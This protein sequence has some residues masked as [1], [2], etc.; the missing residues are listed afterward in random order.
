MS[1]VLKFAVVGHPNEGK[2]SVVSTLA[3]DDTVPV[4]AFPGETVRCASYP[5]KIDGEE[6]IDFIDTP[7]FQN[8][9][10]MKEWMQAHGEDG[11]AL[12]QAFIAAHK[13]QPDYHHDVELLRPI[14]EGAGIIYIVDG[15]RPVRAPDRA[16]ME[17]LRDTGRTR[18]A[19]INSKEAD[20]AHLDEWKLAFSQHFNAYRVFNA[21]HASYRERID[22]LESLKGVNPDWQPVMERVIETYKHD[23]QMRTEHAADILAE[24]LDSNMTCQQEKRVASQREAREL[25]PKMLEAFRA[26][27]SKNERRAHRRI[28]KLFKHTLFKTALDEAGILQE[29]LFS[30]Q[31]WHL[32]G[33]ERN[34]LVA[35]SAIAGAASGL[36]IDALMAGSSLGLW[37]AGGAAIGAASAFFGG[38]RA[39]HSIGKSRFGIGRL[40]GGSKVQVGPV[41]NPQFYFILLDRGLLYVDSIIHW[42]HGRRSEGV[43]LSSENGEKKG[44]V[45]GFSEEA[46]RCCSQHM[47][48]L[49]K[50]NRQELEARRTA[51]Q[52]MLVEVIQ[53]CSRR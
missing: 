29:D 36:G 30:K 15:S 1:A 23:W 22:L 24:L 50:G 47:K 14:A 10:Q 13:D 25:Q 49:R 9:V 45:S 6:I 19:I 39:A 2:S 3:E 40:L 11:E 12:M 16:E 4:S 37:A 34:Q 48:A 17:I 33:L 52:A 32:L 27:L 26:K 46:R 38:E 8:P 53:A 51:V 41:H 43:L 18:M 28:R 21:H 7:G 44:Y 31:T 42:A 5:V 35:A 20:A